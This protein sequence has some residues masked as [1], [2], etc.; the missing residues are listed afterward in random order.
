MTSIEPSS[1]AKKLAILLD[2]K[3]DEKDYAVFFKLQED[4]FKIVSSEPGESGETRV[5]FEFHGLVMNNDEPVSY[6]AQ[7]SVMI[8][9][10]G[11]IKPGSISF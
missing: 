7:G 8:E 5:S 4:T 9:E 6:L 10:S 3:A 2:R 11:E 1:L